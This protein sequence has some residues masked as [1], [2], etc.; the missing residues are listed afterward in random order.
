MIAILSLLM[1]LLKKGL[2]AG[3][4]E[5]LLFPVLLSVYHSLA[6]KAFL[7]ENEFHFIK[8]HA[9]CLSSFPESEFPVEFHD[10]LLSKYSVTRV[11]LST[12]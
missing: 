10:Y 7:K 4:V 12:R 2:Q 3:G 9:W 1:F 6:Q 8:Y 5:P 11:G